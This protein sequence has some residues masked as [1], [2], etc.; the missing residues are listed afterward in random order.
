MDISAGGRH[1]CAILSDN[2]AFC[3]GRNEDNQG[4]RIGQTMPIPDGKFTSVSAGGA[5]S[6][7]I[8]QDNRAVCWGDNLSQQTM[9]TPDREFTSVSAGF[10]HS[11]GITQDN[12]AVCWGG[13]LSQ[14]A[15]PIPDE[16]FI[17]VSAGQF[18]SCGITRD[19]E[20]VCWGSPDDNR[21][22]PPLNRKFISVS[23]ASGL[24][25]CAI[26]LD[27]EAVCWGS[28][29][30]NRSTP[31]SGEKFIAISAGGSHSCGVTPDNRAVC[32]GDNVRRQTMPIPDE[33]FI[34]VSSGVSHNCG[35]T[36]DNMAV[37]WGSNLDRQ[38]APPP[39]APIAADSTT[40]IATVSDSDKL[41]ISI[42]DNGQA[43]IPAGSA[44]AALIASVADD[45]IIEPEIDYIIVLSATGHTELERDEIILTVPVDGGDTEVVGD[46]D[47]T[48]DIV[49]E[50]S[51]VNTEVGVVA[52]ATNATNYNLVDDADG[53]FVISSSGL[54]TV[55]G[56]NP[57]NFEDASSYSVTVEASD[58]FGSTAAFTI[59]VLDVNEFPLGPVTDADAADNA[60]PENATTGSRTG[61]TLSA[62]DEDGSAVVTYA[63]TDSSGNLFAVDGD[64]GRVTL[65]GQLN[66]ERST[67][68]T[69]IA[70]A[71]SDDGSNSTAAFTIVVVDVNEHP[72]GPVSDSDQDTDNAL[73]EHALASSYTGITLSAT[74]ADGSA[75]VTYTLAD[76]SDG[77]FIA[78]TNTGIVTL[79][80]SLDHER[81][82]QHT[83]IGQAM[84]SDGS[85]P[86]TAAFTIAVVDVNEHPVGPVSDSDQD[87]DNALPEHAL[88]SSYTGITLSATDADGSATVTYTLSDSSDG[89]FIADT[90]TGIVTLRGSLDH[91]RSARHTITARAMS[92]D[93]SSS[94]AA[95]TVVVIDV[96]E[97]PVGPVTDSDQD[98][99]NALHEHALASSYTGITLS[100]TDGDGSATVTYT[101]SD[102]ND[103]LFIADTNTGIVTLRGSLDH[104]RSARHTIIARAMSSDGSDPTTAAFTIVVID[105]NEHPVGPITDTDTAD[106]ALHE[107]A[108]A[109]SYTG[110]TLSA[111]DADGSA[112]VTYTLSDSSD[113]L[114]IADTNTGIVT[115]RGS[116]DH[117]RSA[118]HTIIARAMSDDGSSST[119]AF[120]VVVIDV[121][122][123]P[124]GP[125]TDSDQDTDNALHEHA[126][127]SSYTGITL[128]ATDGDGSATVTYTLS[129]SNDGLFI[130]DTNT[131]IVT[132]RG[133]LDHE[134]S[135][136]HTIIARAMSDDGSSS[137]AAFTIVV[138]D[139]NEHP[140]GP[141]SDSDQD[142]DNA[143]HEHALA[144]SYTGITLS[145]TDADGSATVTYTLSD[146]NNGLFLADTNT[147][148]VTLQGQLNHERSTRHTITAQAM[149]SDGS[150]PTT[151]TFTIVVIDV[152]E[153]PVGPVTDTDTADNALPEN[154]AASSHTGITLSATD[155]DGSATVTY[156]LADSSDGL[157]RADTNTGV[158]TLQ[159]SLNYERSTRHTITAQAMSSDGSS[160]TAAFTIAVINVNEITLTDTDSADNTV[161]VPA[162]VTVKG[163]TLEATHAD[164]AA[165]TGWEIT[166]QTGA[167][168]DVDLFEFSEPADSGTQMLR[169]KTDADIASI[170]TPTVITLG[171][172]VSAEDDETSEDFDVLVSP[173][174]PADG[175]RMRIR[176]YL[177]GALE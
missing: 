78:D 145:A 9:P 35:I 174:R 67:R 150:A 31:P 16:E 69:I 112:T 106:N 81:S 111:T 152:N 104:E 164:G 13:N 97:H 24:H 138:A 89:L 42:S 120:T 71:M 136:R 15:M 100:A 20:A 156:T 148:V 68:H 110:I 39:I 56:D 25:S 8:T 1:S 122:E 133:S 55:A 53:R 169:V 162:D 83:I 92:D 113:G 49:A 46:I 54:I 134:R 149:S 60:L 147:G 21:S 168:T 107:H 177:E 171:I 157:F 43:V 126:L 23:A 37:C 103:G 108:L 90:N 161:I 117:E 79:R 40:I 18:H 105:V 155:A 151:Q 2:R 131:G 119:A 77:L 52:H 65:Q 10:S 32:W 17:S 64:S 142:T 50:N 45:N 66:H 99:D 80:G 135:A 160:S 176:V 129:D 44:R 62:E 153:H 63:L 34:A 165:I 29:A 61:I 159:G 158:V 143:L 127:A 130:A 3:W 47:D 115:L 84:S 175:I 128:S 93:G 86:T 173:E 125:V 144:S 163:L 109:S 85:D 48:A 123:H 36:S 132:L 7:G 101:L 98:T 73:P 59:T 58:G 116:L 172:S 5:H 22:S 6:C 121:N 88:A 170:T 11:C 30:H 124:V 94:T 166:A 33:K 70:R 91:E 139:V 74:D 137:T 140:V 38:S 51:P 28:N 12:R 114:F 118:R 102:S 57:L 167:S 26:T 27:N 141:V 95:F 82:T 14:Q 41:Q 96:N 154:A 76:S 75:T 4:M 87:T 72:V 19:N 146:S